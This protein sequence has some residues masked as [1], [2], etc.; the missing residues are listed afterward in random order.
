MNAKQMVCHLG[1]QLRITLGDIP[2]RPMPSPLRIPIVKQL[3]IDVLPWPKGRIIGPREAFV[4]SPAEWQRD[5]TTLLELLE[6]FAQESHRKDWPPHPMF[7]GMSASLWSRLTCRH[8][9]HH[10]RQFGV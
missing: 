1:D 8:F 5:I 10:L 2:T 7:G 6:R 4:T 9:D 3:V